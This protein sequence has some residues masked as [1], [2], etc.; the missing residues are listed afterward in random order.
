MTLTVDRT[1]PNVVSPPLNENQPVATPL[2]SQ[3]APSDQSAQARGD[4]E[5]ALLYADGLVRGAQPSQPYPGP[6]MIGPIPLQST[7]GQYRQQLKALLD[8]PDFTSWAKAQNVDL[9]K[10]FKLL[11]PRGGK[12]GYAVLSVKSVPTASGGI[13]GT[14]RRRLAL[15]SSLKYF[16]ESTLTH[17]HTLPLSW[18]LIMQATE[19]LAN[20]AFY[21]DVDN[22]HSADLSAVAS[23][24]GET[25]P[26][27]RESAVERADQLRQSNAFG[28]AVHR[29][30]NVDDVLES[31]KQAA[32][33]NN[34]YVFRNA[35]DGKFLENFEDDHAR[36]ERDTRLPKSHINYRN[37]TQHKERI[38][39]L[40]ARSLRETMMPI[41][42]K[43][44]YRQ[45]NGLEPGEKVSLM[46]FIADNGWPV[47]ASL[48]EFKDL[49]INVTA[50]VPATPSHG[51]FS[52]ALAWPVP[53]SQQD[54]A[55]LYFHP[56]QILPGVEE[57][58]LFNV[59]T[60]NQTWD[61]TTLSQPRR[62]LEG[63]LSSRLGKAIGEQL[64]REFGAL[65]TPDSSAD[66][67]LAALHASLDEASIV[68]GTGTRNTVA[69]LQL[70]KPAYY[71]VPICEMAGKLAA[72][73]QVQGKA[74]GE[75]ARA[76]AHCLLSRRAPA[77]LVNDIPA[78]VTSSCHSWVSLQVAVARLEF[79]AP[80]S[81]ALMSYGQVMSLATSPPNS[82]EE[83]AIEYRAQTNALK[84]WGVAR[85]LI[86]VNPQDQYTTAQMDAVRLAFAEMMKEIGSA[87]TTLAAPMPLRHEMA[88]ENLRQEYGDNIDYELECFYSTKDDKG[89]HSLLDLYLRR[90]TGGDLVAGW[91]SK[92]ARL[93]T[94]LIHRA[95]DLP[96]INLM[97][98]QVFDDYAKDMD[99]ATA[100]QVK[101]LIATLPLQDR[102][103]IEVGKLAI[104]KDIE[105]TIGNYGSVTKVQLP[106]KQAVMLR[107]V[108]N[109][110]R[111][112][113]EV[114][115][116]QNR[117]TQRQ[118]LNDATPGLK[119]DRQSMRAGHTYH[120]YPTV[121]PTGNFAATVTHEKPAIESIPDSFASE[122]SAY[123]AAALVKNANIQG[124]KAQ[125]KGLSTFESRQ[126]F[127]QNFANLTLN[128]VPFYSAIKHFQ[129][130]NIVDGLVD[131][132]FDVLSVVVAVGVTAK[133]IKALKAG[134][135]TLAT[136]IKTTQIVGRAAVG[137]LN[138]LDDI[139]S[140]AAKATNHLKRGL[141]FEY[142]MLTQGADVGELF[143]GVK[144]I[145]AS[146]V[147]TFR[148][149]NE[150]MEGPSVFKHD[151]WY[152]YN[153]VTR[154]PYG[155]PLTD[156][157]PS[158]RLNGKALD[159]WTRATDPVKQI[160]D[161]VEATWKRTVAKYRDTADTT[162]FEQGYQF[163]LPSNVPGL[164]A[165]A[166][167]EDL[168]KLAAR[169]DITAQQVGVLVKR[170]DEIA[171]KF[172]RQGSRR[173]FD[174]IEP[175]FGTFQ[176][177][178]QV[179]Y[180]SQTGQLSRGQ[181]AALS[182]VMASAVA[183]GKEAQFL[184]NMM[185]AAAFPKA[186]ESRAFMQR[187]HDLQKKIDLPTLFRANQPFELRSYQNM[188]THLGEAS[189]SKSIMIDSPGHAMAAGVRIDDSGKTFY[190][191][192]PNQ[193]LAKFSN[194]KA[195]EGALHKVFTDK[196]LG[197]HYKTHSVDP[198]K[199]EF[200]VFDHND[201]W[202][203]VVTVQS[204]Q[205][206]AFYE[207]PILNPTTQPIRYLPPP[208]NAVR[209]PIKIKPQATPNDVQAIV[210]S[211]VNLTDVGGHKKNIYSGLVFRGDMRPPLKTD[212]AEAGI[213]ETGFTLR[214]P[215]SDVREVNGTRGG[216]GGG[217]DALDPDGRG[218]STSVYYDKSGAGAYYYGG[219]KGGHT[220]LVDGRNMEGFHLYANRHTVEH[221]AHR[222]VSLSP[223]EINYGSDIPGHRIIGAFD[224]SGSFISNPGYA[225]KQANKVTA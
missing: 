144:N 34:L 14:V 38:K 218:I 35:P 140:A 40:L 57:H 7:Y 103:I 178:P 118:D 9:S 82:L 46:R 171:L 174:C 168:M 109:G 155:P 164:K 31:Q 70:D 147:G 181:C 220:Y 166:T 1:N 39:R 13:A 162:A 202:Q 96:P 128:L 41:D 17:V 63:T 25:V 225:A 4:A 75:C 62:I 169:D 152:A 154:Q 58:G 64:Q 157:I 190:F 116:A 215:I 69:G 185:D 52:G 24:Y 104:F 115:L 50:A 114:D 111:Y 47:P 36:A 141:V 59:L 28:E 19:Q 93:P 30:L 203:R 102:K 153:P 6:N 219:H 44:S 172:G 205:I 187:L 173:F 122:R 94:S 145:D 214:T 67:L 68:N 99:K 21:V 201:A 2:S 78:R 90:G 126:H 183:E 123:I 45:E 27:T 107:V 138:P 191:Y 108:C 97:F 134:T 189:A 60:R 37:P 176:P 207:A 184:Q 87:S 143:K 86:P 95:N 200:K 142:K 51:N 182:R 113:Y 206:K 194:A 32:D 216:F 213:F 221:P 222:A 89:F 56:L 106:G 55:K 42:Y 151:N 133:G 139:G 43:S 160:D 192:D 112:T 72:H 180:L 197:K 79:K 92:D 11:P 84:D 65:T 74:S 121:T 209:H 177:M 167:L 150:F 53:L 198:H 23:F 212:A 186:P 210:N 137:V 170:Y 159:T 208:V 48:K 224:S 149:N 88:K 71:G 135:S 130:G 148:Y 196:Q 81:T 165:S 61:K 129:E 127:Y 156:F 105:I 100:V 117:I 91:S 85:G 120:E 193:G 66:W 188:V 217:R 26:A 18:P 73:L 12:P 22:G 49:G 204:S 98:D 223:W 76:A 83:Q 16:G 195:M 158:M 175:H 146:A 119:R 199:L 101:H 5:L 131:L 3:R 10:P 124:L 54:Q 15:G 179:V 33:I 29:R 163:G 125:A 132:A 136:G 80:G 20:G 110:Q 211:H 77:Y 161:A 8:G